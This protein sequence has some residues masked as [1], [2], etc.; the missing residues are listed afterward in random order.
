[1]SARFFFGGRGRVLGRAE[2]LAR[3]LAQ[4]GPQRGVPTLLADATVDLFKALV[5]SVKANPAYAGWG[6]IILCVL[7]GV[8]FLKPH[9]ILKSWWAQRKDEKLD[10]AKDAIEKLTEIQTW[11]RIALDVSRD[12][13]E[14]VNRLRVGGEERELSLGVLHLADWTQRLYG[15]LQADIN[16]VTLWIPIGN[17]L[18][19][20]AYNGMRPESAAEVRLKLETRGVQRPPF[21]VL[22]FHSQKIEICTDIDADPRYAPLNYPAAHPYKSIIAVPL[23]VKG[24]CVG[25]LTIDS[26]RVGAFDDEDAKQLAQLCGSLMALYFNPP[27]PA[28]AAEPGTGKP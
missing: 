1:V 16:K 18:Q 27:G 28:A 17:E 13:V 26:V 10:A 24:E 21:A 14:R 7:I 20:Y 2:G 15:F 22:A 5:D 3:A 6:I 25:V 8:S 11:L 12:S 23:L 9:E 19:V 4:K